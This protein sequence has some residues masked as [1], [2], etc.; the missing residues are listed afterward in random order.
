MI[1]EYCERS[2][3]S[4]T[5]LLRHQN[6]TTC[7][8][9]KVY[10]ENQS[11]KLLQQYQ[12][13][14]LALSQQYHDE[15]STIQR[16]HHDEIDDLQCE[17]A[18]KE[19]QIE[20][21]EKE[22]TQLEKELIANKAT[23]ETLKGLVGKSGNNT[24]NNTNNY[25]YQTL[26]V[27]DLTPE[28]IQKIFDDHYTRR[29]FQWGIKGLGRFVVE[30][31]IINDEGKYRGGITDVNRGTLVYIDS[32]RGVVKDGRCLGLTKMVYDP[33][34]KRVD[35]IIKDEGIVIHKTTLYGTQDE[36]A[37]AES[38]AYRELQSIKNDN[39]LF[40]DEIVKGVPQV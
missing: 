28:R 17:L 26:V 3:V 4:K 21:L 39:R 29:D 25:I 40:V 8:K 38:K 13:K 32:E 35:Q 27:F 6:T 23:I 37:N 33:C 5:S 7:S 15:L 30:R 1:C 34:M 11:D 9:F 24:T 2:F 22:N 19:E 16:Q 18:L 14:L 20:K 12:D 36:W 10:V 31:V